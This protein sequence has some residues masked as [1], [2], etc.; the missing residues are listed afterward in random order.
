MSEEYKKMVD[1]SI[2]CKRGL[3]KP[4][5]YAGEQL[6]P[7]WCW[8]NRTNW[9][10]K[11]MQQMAITVKLH[12]TYSCYLA[13]A[14]LLIGRDTWP[15]SWEALEEQR[16]LHISQMTKVHTWCCRHNGSDGNVLLVLHHPWMRS[17]SLISHPR[18]NFCSQ[19][20]TNC[21]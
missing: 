1:K 12:K 8:S 17:S 16:E 20:I 19:V 9:K 13:K 6:S 2:W 10:V 3:A 18:P 7:S 4:L 21:L 5:G 14:W 11:G 15:I